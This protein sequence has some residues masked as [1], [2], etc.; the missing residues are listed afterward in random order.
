MLGAGRSL[1]GRV[2]VESSRGVPS[3]PSGLQYHQFRCRVI[4]WTL[5][6]RATRTAVGVDNDWPRNVLHTIMAACIG[7]GRDADG[8]VTA[9]STVNALEP[10]QTASENYMS[11]S[12]HV[13]FLILRDPGPTSFVQYRDAAATT[14]TRTGVHV[15]HQTLSVLGMS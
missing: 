13:K 6:H 5:H 9:I 3:H 8:G 15:P 10:A 1:S 4:S 11:C 12:H 7:N 14:G 2:L